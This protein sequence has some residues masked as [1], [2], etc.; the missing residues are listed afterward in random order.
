VHERRNDA[1]LLLVALREIADAALER[2]LEA[3]GE[4]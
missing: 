2:K 4:L 1:D 3:F